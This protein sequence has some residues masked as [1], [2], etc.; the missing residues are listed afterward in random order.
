LLIEADNF[1]SQ[2]LS[3]AKIL[4]QQDITSELKKIAI[5]LA[6]D[7]GSYS[8]IKEDGIEIRLV[9]HFYK[10]IKDFD[11]ER[12][13]DAQFD[14]I[15]QEIRSDEYLLDYFRERIVSVISNTEEKYKNHSSSSKLFS[16]E[17][18]VY[19]GWSNTKQL[20]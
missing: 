2:V 4:L 5:S 15:W 9:T 1:L 6:L 8:G 12:L 10:N 13:D 7:L 16:S 20:K 18:M 17:Q 19:I 14:E 11:E 3:M